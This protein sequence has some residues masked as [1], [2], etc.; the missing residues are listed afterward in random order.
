MEA[1][2]LNDIINPRPPISEMTLVYE[3]LCRNG[4]LVF[5]EVHLCFKLKIF[6]RKGTILLYHIVN[7]PFKSIKI[8]LSN[9]YHS[10]LFDF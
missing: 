2:E 7:W 10:I 5:N 6:L 4:E 1:F 8:F 9:S 3:S